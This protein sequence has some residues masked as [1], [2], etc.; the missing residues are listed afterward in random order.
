MTSE[1]LPAGNPSGVRVNK[2]AG[3]EER[4]GREQ[5]TQCQ[6]QQY[7]TTIITINPSDRIELGSFSGVL[8]LWARW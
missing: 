1:L 8:S 6:G 3:S 5:Q 4:C 7:I 2:R